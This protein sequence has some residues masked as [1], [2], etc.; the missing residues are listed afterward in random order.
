MPEERI[1]SQSKK[2]NK[3][4]VILLIF[5]SIFVLLCYFVLNNP[6][7]FEKNKKTPVT[8]MYSDKVYSYIFYPPDFDADITENEEYMG[9]DRMLHYKKGN[10]SEGITEDDGAEHS[11]VI[12][13]FLQ[14]FKTVM[15]G[16]VDTYNTFFTDEYYEKY[17]PYRIFA[18]QMIYNIQVEERSVQTFEDGTEKYSFDVSYMI[19]RNDGT[20]RNDIESDASKTLFYEVIEYPNGE[21][22]IN[23]ITYYR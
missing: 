11:S 23:N 10:I 22:K 15:A 8:S 19:F 13:F 7:I 4:I 12:S 21:V 5:I 17:E 16:D 18:P 14:Y 9:L 20:F 2:R 6:Q 3:K 1:N